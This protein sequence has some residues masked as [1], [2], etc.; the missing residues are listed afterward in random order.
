MKDKKGRKAGT[1]IGV[2]ATVVKEGYVQAGCVVE[3]E[4][5][6]TFRELEYV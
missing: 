6:K 2:Y 4:S 1:K 3:V 5:P